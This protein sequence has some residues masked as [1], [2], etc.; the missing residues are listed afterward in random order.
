VTKTPE[1]KK[2]EIKNYKKMAL[3]SPNLSNK[4]TSLP[5]GYQLSLMK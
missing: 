1:V 4:H 3:L 2:E 5:W